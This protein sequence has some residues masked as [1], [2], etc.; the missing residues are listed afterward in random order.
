MTTGFNDIG[1]ILEVKNKEIKEMYKIYRK[2][3]IA[4]SN[5]IRYLKEENK[6]LEEEIKRLKDIIVDSRDCMTMEQLVEEYSE[7]GKDIDTIV[8]DERLCD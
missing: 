6:K 4:L 8:D 3:Y 2:E 7:N 5:Q 1:P